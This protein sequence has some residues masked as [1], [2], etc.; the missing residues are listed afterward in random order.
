MSFLAPILGA[1]GGS[2]ISGLFGNAANKSNQAAQQNAQTSAQQFD[3]KQLQQMIDFIKSQQTQAFGNLANYLA[4]NPSP[5]ANMPPIALPNFSGQPSTIGG[6]QLGASGSLESSAMTPQLGG[7]PN[8]NTALLDALWPMLLQQMPQAAPPAAQVKQAPSPTSP[9]N[10]PAQPRN[11][12][13][14][15]YAIPRYLQQ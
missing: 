9:I 2:L 15:R 3:A 4:K 13:P 8:A 12:G 6:Q 14:G 10:F 11:V 5:V 1:V 7:D